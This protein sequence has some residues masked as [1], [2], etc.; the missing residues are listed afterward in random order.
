MIGYGRLYFNKGFAFNFASPMGSLALPNVK[1]LV[2]A[3][4]DYNEA[5]H[6]PVE[7]FNPR[8]GYL[9]FI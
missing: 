7:N 1:R 2:K 5:V 4:L 9:I 3:G 8:Q 6:Q